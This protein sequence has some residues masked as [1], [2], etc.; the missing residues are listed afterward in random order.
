MKYAMDK[1]MEGGDDENGPKRR[2]IGMSLFYL[3]RIF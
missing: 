3:I 2:V 1:E